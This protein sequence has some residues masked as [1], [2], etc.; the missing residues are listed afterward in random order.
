ML[1]AACLFYNA[2]KKWSVH[3]PSIPSSFA[4]GLC[5][6]AR[7]TRTSGMPLPFEIFAI[8]CIN[9]A[10]HA[11]PWWKQQQSCNYRGQWWS[12]ERRAEEVEKSGS[13]WLMRLLANWWCEGYRMAVVNTALQLWQDMT[14]R[15]GMFESYIDLVQS[16]PTSSTLLSLP[17]QSWLRRRTWMP[18][19][20]SSRCF[21]V[22][23][24]AKSF[25]WKLWEAQG[26]LTSISFTWSSMKNNKGSLGLTSASLF[27]RLFWRFCFVFLLLQQHHHPRTWPRRKSSPQSRDVYLSQRQDL[28]WRWGTDERWC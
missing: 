7:L 6:K 13:A 24:L 9:A 5:W 22:W 2:D 15:H 1:F 8:S 4:Q 18:T 12:Q 3:T 10:W 16:P 26:C 28:L 17:V 21:H 11:T 23:V 19:T 20:I 14:I 25:S 27:L